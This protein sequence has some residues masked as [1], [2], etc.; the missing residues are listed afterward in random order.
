[1]VRKLVA[2]SSTLLALVLVACGGSSIGDPGGGSPPPGNKPPIG[3]GGTEIVSGNPQM[4]A[5]VPGDITTNE[6]HPGHTVRV[7]NE[8]RTYFFRVSDSTLVFATSTDVISGGPITKTNVVRLRAA[9]A[10]D[11]KMDHPFVLRRTDGKFLLIYDYYTD[12]TN[13]TCC[14]QQMVSRIS[15]DGITWGP[16]VPLPASDQDNSPGT[17]KPFMGVASLLQ[18]PDG[19]IRA[20]YTSAGGYVGSALTADGGL[21][22]TEDAGL[23][24][25]GVTNSGYGEP[26]AVIDTDG[27][28][29]VYTGFQVF[30]CSQADPTAN[31]FEI[32]LARSTDGL[33]FK[34][35]KE[36]VVSS[37]SQLID[38]NLF[39]GLD[40]KMRLLLGV[41]GTGGNP[42]RM[43]LAERSK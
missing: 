8:F 32:K 24:I 17:K 26:N 41:Q 20:Y 33:N 12:P 2:L 30:G 43:W 42:Q 16:T 29:L 15:D 28:V 10:P 3:S 11:T 27:S 36:D 9:G 35:Y 38:G 14:A 5:L 4:W 23:R 25:Q 19:S 1:M 7:G 6:L 13:P 18:L 21:T 39:V 22:W 31:C 34:V 40:G 37:T